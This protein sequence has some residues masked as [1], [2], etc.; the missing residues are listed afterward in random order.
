MKYQLPGHLP[1]ETLA[2]GPAARAYRVAEAI[3]AA[4]L[5]NGLT[6]DGW[7][8]RL[9]SAGVTALACLALGRHAFVPAAWILTSIGVS[10]AA[11]AAR[12][13][14]GTQ[15]GAIAL[16]IAAHCVG[17][18]L[19]VQIGARI[20]WGAIFF[21]ISTTQ[22][23]YEDSTAILPSIGFYL[24]Q[25][26]AQFLLLHFGVSLDFIWHGVFDATTSLLAVMLAVLQGSVIVE[27]TR[28]LTRRHETAIHSNLELSE[29]AAH[30][31]AQATALLRTEAI[32]RA[33]IGGSEDAVAVYD[34]H[35]RVLV[36]NPRMEMIS[37]VR[38]S[39]ALGRPRSEVIE[40]DPARLR[41]MESALAGTAAH[42]NNVAYTNRASG[43]AGVL[44]I[45][46]LPLRGA[47]GT[48][49][50]AFKVAHDVSERI[51]AADAVSTTRQ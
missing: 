48:L 35:A 34:I 13:W 2:S 16:G 27:I 19:S 45:A 17:W 33:V 26:V 46:Y 11:F 12:E 15:H 30:A 43:V 32:M 31:A 41:A 50:G 40:S 24:M 5:G 22:I 3:A 1:Y 23:R 44:D 51:R 37:G 14:R 10:I 49:I 8:L 36:W 4:K 39:M 6:G 9:I 28:A 38:A 29:R 42:V 21:V 18:A 7:M 47:D 20:E 25:H